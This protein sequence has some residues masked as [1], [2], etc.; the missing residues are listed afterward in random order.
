MRIR[1]IIQ[2][3]MILMV[4]LIFN[5]CVANHVPFYVSGKTETLAEVRKQQEAEDYLERFKAR[6]IKFEQE[7]SAFYINTLR[8]SEVKGVLTTEGIMFTNKLE[9]ELRAQFDA[10]EAAALAQL[11][12]NL[13]F[14][15]D[16]IELQGMNRQSITQA[17]IDDSAAFQ[18][19][20]VELSKFTMKE[21]QAAADRR[22][23]YLEAKET[24]ADR[25]FQTPNEPPVEEPPLE[26]PPL[27]EPP[28][29]LDPPVPP[30]TD[31]ID[32]I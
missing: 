3:T 6:R 2:I 30:T 14:Y 17:Q 4:A 10:N 18:E 26:E 16:I 9:S 7:L 15:D 27:E 25:R 23:A 24:L 19:L 1:Q 31:S 5:A 12:K 11:E 22:L 32:V 13:L 29:P 28:V 8:E 21:L 20:V